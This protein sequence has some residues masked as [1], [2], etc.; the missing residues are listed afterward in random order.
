[1]ENCAT[2][3]LIFC[4]VLCLLVILLLLSMDSL[5]P[6]QYGITYNKFS[7]KI[8]TEVFESGRYLIGPF[9]N[10]VVYPA[11]LITIEFSDNRNAVS[12]ALQTRTAEGLA[13]QLHVSYQYRLTKDKI[14]ELYNLANV[15]Y[16]VTLI[17]MSRDVFMKVGGLYNATSYWTERNKIGDYMK[18]K[19]N[20]ELQKAFATCEGLQILKVDLPKSYEDSIVLTQ[21]E[22]QKTNMRKFEQDAELIRQDINVLV[23]SADQSIKITNA[24]ALGEA[25][26][27]KQFATATALQNTIDTE[28]QVYNDAKTQIALNDKDFSDYVYYTNLMDQKNAKILVGLQTSIINFGNQISDSS[29]NK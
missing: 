8:G 12:A 27:I 29:S 17:R 3:S 24:T 20:D 28:A 9:Q 26:K 16:Q 22:V 7:K 21:V 1:M 5:E 11:N 2:I 18:D 10:F 25:Y 4:I 6:L 19:L 14:P 15:N 13:L 23:S